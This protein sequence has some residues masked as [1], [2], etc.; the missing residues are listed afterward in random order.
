MSPLTDPAVLALLSLT[1]LALLC[2]AAL[3]G[4]ARLREYRWD[5]PPPRRRGG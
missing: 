5:N 4:H 1:A 2:A 3:W